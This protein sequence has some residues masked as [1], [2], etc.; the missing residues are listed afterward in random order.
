VA[1]HQAVEQV[2]YVLLLGMKVEYSSQADYLGGRREGRTL[3]TKDGRK[4][5]DSS[6]GDVIVSLST[7]LCRVAAL[8]VEGLTIF[9]ARAG[10]TVGRAL[11]HPYPC[12]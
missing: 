6:D 5:R 9:M 10:Q 7:S 3:R 4:R 11:P 1:A 12:G 2:W 8:G